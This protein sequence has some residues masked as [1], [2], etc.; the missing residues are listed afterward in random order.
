MSTIFAILY[1]NPDD[2]ELTDVLQICKSKEDAVASL[3]ELAHYRKDGED[4]VTQYYDVMENQRSFSSLQKEVSENMMLEDVDI[5]R[6]I[7]LSSPN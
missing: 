3:I 5:Y 7:P 6:I 4:G 1:I 2:Y